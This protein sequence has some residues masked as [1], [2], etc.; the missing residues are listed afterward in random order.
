MER[1]TQYLNFSHSQIEDTCRHYFKGTGT[2]QSFEILSGGAVNTTYKICWND[3]FYVLRFFI[4]DKIAASIENNLYQMIQ[5]KIPVPKMLFISSENKSYPFAIFKFYEKPHLYEIEN[6]FSQKLSYDLGKSLARIH[7]FTFPQAGLFG[8]DL[9]IDVLFKKGSSPYFEYCIENLIPNSNAWKRLGGD[10][11]ERVESFIKRHYKY[12]PIIG[13]H[14]CLVHSDFKPVNLLWNEGFG[15]TILDWEFAHSG[16]GMI[17]FGILLRHF[18]DFPLDLFSLEKGYLEHGGF[19]QSDWIQR[20][21]IVDFINVIQL[22]NAPSE[23]PVLYQSLIQSL[24]YTMR[25]WNSLTHFRS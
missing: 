18:R 17:D 16:D 24:D 1:A 13:D 21:R 4:R 8:P 5:E 10:R 12:F 20:A 23:R 9:N 6:S 15:L 3:K 22:L 2:L 14:G 19:L 11:A 7:S 25:Y